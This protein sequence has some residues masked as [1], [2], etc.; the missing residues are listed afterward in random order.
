MITHKY[1][2]KPKNRSI[3]TL[4]YLLEDMWLGIILLMIDKRGNRMDKYKHEFVKPMEGLEFYIS[5]SEDKGSVVNKHFHD[6]IEIVYIVRGELEFQC[7]NQK[8]QLYE[9]D[10]IVVNPMCIH[11]THCV[12]GNTAILLQIPMSFLK[13]FMP[14]INHYYFEVDIH[15]DII[16]VQKTVKEIKRIIKELWSTTQVHSDEGQLKCYSLVFELMYILVHQCSREINIRDLSKS[17]KNMER[18]QQ[19]MEFIKE[20]YTENISLNRISSEFGLNSIY[21]S[22]FFKKQMGVTFLEYLSLVRIENIYSDLINSD[23]TIKEIIE[24]NGFTNYKLFMKMFK[25][26]YGCTPKEAR[27]LANC[28]SLK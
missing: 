13:M 18:I 2:N 19:I 1:L 7:N 28:P 26:M 24:R 25:T 20:H 15:S 16:T 12:S 6:W 17:K 14:N 22:R 4:F 21:F 23:L 3:L 9:D 11:S 8:I 10:F 5:Q 27:H